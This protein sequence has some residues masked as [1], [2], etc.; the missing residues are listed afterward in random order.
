MIIRKEESKSARSVLLED[1]N[2]IDVYVEDTAVESKKIYKEILNRIFK[3]QYSIDDV[4]PVGS[5]SK[6]IAEWVKHKKNAD[7][8]PKVFIIDGDF[9][10]F[11]KN[12]CSIIPE[13]FKDD[14]QGL[15]VL[16]RYCIEN[17]LIDE[18]ALIEIVH[19]EEAVDEREDIKR[20]I[21][22][23]GWIQANESLLKDLFIVYSICLENNVPEKTISYKV[24]NFVNT[25]DGCVND[26]LINGRIDHLKEK[27]ILKNSE[28]NIDE[29]I[30]KRD[31]YISGK[32]NILLRYITG[33]NYLFPLV[34]QRISSQYNLS[35]SQI[36]LKIRLAKKCDL[37]E[38]DNLNKSI[39]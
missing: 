38:L 22:F 12:L 31:N 26:V 4:I 3:D 10:H 13:E 27:I 18:N 39:M 23:E 35:V 8:R 17:Y 7:D 14:H 25:T 1:F 15:F 37:S 16:P 6:V 33:K 2:D 11:N 19:D 34:K 30:E 28:L 5:C 21:D 32:E 36:S 29:E 24:T 20:K 9:I